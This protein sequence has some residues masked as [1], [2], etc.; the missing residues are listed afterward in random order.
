VSGSID[1]L[2]AWS[3]WLSGQEVDPQLSIGPMTVLWWSRVGKIAA[4]IGG[5]TVILDLV[6]PERLRRV[7]RET[8]PQPFDRA[9]SFNLLV[10]PT[11]VLV[12]TGVYFLTAWDSAST[13]LRSAIVFASLFIIG[14]VSYMLILPVISRILDVSKPGQL[15]RYIGVALL[16]LGFHFDLLA[17]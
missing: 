13:A 7:G 16:L 10:P 5:A 1:L 15:L 11:V 4:F 3:L 2:D 9:V 6:G 17:S 8:G 14:P 12:A